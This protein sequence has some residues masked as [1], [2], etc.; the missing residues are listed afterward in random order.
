MEENGHLCQNLPLAFRLPLHQYLND[1]SYR[2]VEDSGGTKLRC[3]NGARRMPG[4][5][6]SII[7]KS[8]I[9]L[10]SVGLVIAINCKPLLLFMTHFLCYRFFL[11]RSA[12]LVMV[13][14]C[15]R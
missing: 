9:Y 14:P 6:R 8:D 4:V 13:G 3:V 12:N 11:F 5:C 15:C 7:S 1:E 10:D 2:I